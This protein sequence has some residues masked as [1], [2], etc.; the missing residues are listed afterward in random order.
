MVKKLALKSFLSGLGIA[1]KI[2][3]EQLVI[4]ELLSILAILYSKLVV[5]Y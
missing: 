1:N 4:E 5:H 2:I 3:N